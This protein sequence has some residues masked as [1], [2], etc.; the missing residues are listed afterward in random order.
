M[1]RNYLSLDN[2][3]AALILNENGTGN[4]SYTGHPNG[5]NNEYSIGAGA[6]TLGYSYV[7]GS[8]I[9]NY[10]LLHG[11]KQIIYSFTCHCS[12]NAATLSYWS[13]AAFNLLVDNQVIHNQHRA[14]SNAQYRDGTINVHFV[15]DITDGTQD[16]AHGKLNW[17]V[18]DTK[19]IKLE[20]T[21]RYDTKLHS[22]NI[23]ILESPDHVVTEII[24]P[25]V[26]LTATGEE[27]TVNNIVPYGN[28][29]IGTT[30]PKATLNINT[31][32]PDNSNTIRPSNSGDTVYPTESLWLGK[33]RDD[34][35]YGVKNYWGMSLGTTWDGYGYIQ[36]LNTA[37]SNYYNLSL[38]PNGGNVGIGT[39]TPGAGLH[40]NSTGNQNVGPL[41]FYIQNGGTVTTGSQTL[42]NKPIGLINEHRTWF[43]EMYI[44]LV[45]KN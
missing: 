7:T 32:L 13:Q 21:D 22:P 42:Y 41:T 34:I 26:E 17:T 37:T 16:I 4:P 29:G 20:A 24:K 1:Q 43:K 11:T 38:Q 39:T 14:E 5:T 31:P 45:K 10:K 8:Q 25:Q 36:I 27:T 6:V 3:T 44:L 15:I 40:I 30:N 23:Y 12:N 33:S 18:G 19:T 35:E 2:V 28:V 9:T